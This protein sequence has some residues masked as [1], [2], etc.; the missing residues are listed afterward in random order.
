MILTE[1]K[2]IIIRLSNII[3]AKTINKQL[4]KKIIK[5]IKEGVDAVSAN[6]QIVV[7]RKLKNGNL[8]VFVNSPTAKKKIKSIID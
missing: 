8:A 5:R 4:K 2:R 1:D 6:R 3:T 7:V